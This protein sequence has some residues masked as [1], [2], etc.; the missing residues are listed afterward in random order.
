ML[1]G[2]HEIF[3]AGG[4]YESG[5]VIGVEGFGGEEGDEILVAEF[6]GRAPVLGVGG[7]EG[8]V[9][10]LLVPLI[11]I[12]R[13]RKKPP[14]HGNAEFGVNEPLR[15]LIVGGDGIPGRLHGA[16]GDGGLGS[17]GGGDNFG[18]Y[19]RPGLGGGDVGQCSERGGGQE[20]AG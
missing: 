12:C 10:V 13:D 11:V 1:T 17:S 4:F 8:R 5:H 3:G 15:D 7:G 2:G 20:C 19:R 6:V 16:V 18:G 9:H 14:V